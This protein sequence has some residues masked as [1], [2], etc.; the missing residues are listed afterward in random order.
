MQNFSEA[1]HIRNFWTINEPAI[2]AFSRYVRGAFSPGI[3]MDFPKAA[4]F[5]VGAFKAHNIAYDI[6]HSHYNFAIVGFTHQY[7]KFLGTNPLFFLITKYLTALTNDATLGTLET[8]IFK[9]KIPF[10]CNV[11][12]RIPLKVDQMGVQVYTRPVIGFTGSTGFYDEPQ[13]LMPFREDPAAAYEAVLEVARVSQKPVIVTE[14]GISTNDEAQRARYLE[15]VFYALEAARKKG[16]Q[17]YGQQMVNP[18]ILRGVNL[19]TFTDQLEW[20]M[21]MKPQAFGAYPLTQAGEIAG[22]FRSGVQPFIDSSARW[23]ASF[24]ERDAEDSA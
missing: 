11:E 15:R 6:I 2:E 9:L 13:T 21:G 7:L 5:L 24:P 17:L 8:C 14:T 10:L 22:I 16:I 3:K 23:R 18:P 19:W 12:E 20:D 4:A 1:R